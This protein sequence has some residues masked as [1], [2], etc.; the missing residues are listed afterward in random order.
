MLAEAE[1]CPALDRV[2]LDIAA[3]CGVNIRDLL[4]V[5]SQ[6]GGVL[7]ATGPSL[8]RRRIVHLNT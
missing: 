8:E 6:G 7:V 1:D 4:D 5:L 2:R 3:D